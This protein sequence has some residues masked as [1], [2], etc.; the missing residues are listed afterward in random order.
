MIDIDLLRSFTGENHLVSSVIELE[1]ADSTNTYAKNKDVPCGTIKITEN[2]I[3]GKGRMGRK[4]ISEA[5]SS[6]TFSIKAKLPLFPAENHFAVFFYSYHLYSAI[7]K[8]LSG[9]LP[10]KEIK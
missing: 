1:S 4:W 3:Q 5:G 8:K 7:Y 6:L 9:I 10:E 2:Q